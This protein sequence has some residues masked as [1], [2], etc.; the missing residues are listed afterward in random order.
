MNYM[1]A[2]QQ[3]AAINYLAENGWRYDLDR[4]DPRGEWRGWWLHEELRP[5]RTGDSQK[6]HYAAE[7]AFFAAGY[8]MSDLDTTPEWMKVYAAA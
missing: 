7:L 8:D 6:M 1:P 2:N 5:R 4:N 3:T